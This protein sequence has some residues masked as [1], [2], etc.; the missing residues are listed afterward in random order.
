MNVY[1]KVEVRDR[2]FL[3]RFLLGATSALKGNDVLIGDD[4]V[5]ELV[6][7]KK[8]NPGIILEK[9]ISPVKRRIL[10]L[11]NYKH[12]NC[13]VTS[14][15]EEGGLAQ[16]KYKDFAN[17]R[18][19]Y[20]TLSYADKIFCWGN[21]DYLNNIKLF[22]KAKKKFLITGNPRFDL[23]ENKIAKNFVKR[24]K[25]KSNTI[26]IISS[27]MVFTRSQSFSDQF[28]VN[29]KFKD[30]YFYDHF[31][32]RAAMSSNY[33][34]LLKKIIEEFPKFEIDIWIH[35]NESIQ[36]WKKIL[37]DK[38]NIR[39]TFGEKFLLKEKNDKTIYIHSGSGLAFNAILQEKIVISYQP[40]KSNWNNTLP[41]VNSIKIKSDKEFINFLK[42]KKMYKIKPNTFHIKRL[43]R[44]I[45]NS[46][47][48][49]ACEKIASYWE[50]FNNDNLNIKNNLSKIIIKN[51]I[52]LIR[53]SMKY[54]IYNKKFPP[55][56][57][58]QLSKLKK[59]LFKVNPK[60]KNL[61]FSLI[62][63]KLI[64]ISKL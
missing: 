33:I 9:S 2:E 23:L 17:R 48:Y 37:P 63:P 22:P 11:K 25:R 39:F 50:N 29:E 51:K 7:K 59:I 3:S 32:H 28:S 12:N 8:L 43:H 4:E 36:N 49:D 27:Y 24:K 47:N 44:L 46:K 20:Q 35:P 58:D 60:F 16:I 18:Y 41:N 56:T 6:E 31:S 61:K 57:K 19:S 1:I 54:R 14:I 64:N 42:Q 15:D 45:N 30:D 55:F 62:G 34:K 21:Y 38:K 26:V 10:Q 5:L 40:I 13:I 52:R 53:Q